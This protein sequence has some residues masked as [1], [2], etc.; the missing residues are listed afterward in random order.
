MSTLAWNCKRLGNRRTVRALEK[1]VSSEDPN[2]IFLMETKLIV[3]EMIGIKE[4]LNRTQVMVVPCKGRSGGLALLWKKELK[5]DVQSYSDSH[6]DAIVSPGED[7]LQWRLAS[8]YGNLE[9]SKREESWRLL[10]RLS[11][12]FSL[13]WV[14]LGDFNELMYGAEKEGGNP[15]PVKQME[16]FCEV[17]N[18]CNLRDLGYTGQDFTWCRRL[19][20]RGWV[21]ER[22]D[23]VLVS[24]NWAAIFP[25]TRLHHK[26]DSSFD[27]CILVLKDV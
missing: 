13:P 22:L 25:Q 8:F 14:C 11:S 9:T 12:L 4:S 23:K 10:K 27:H 16:N 20:N 21:R 7:G 17:I 18:A 1:V 26:L 3:S 15:H 6:I 2:F 19:G 5:V 24:T